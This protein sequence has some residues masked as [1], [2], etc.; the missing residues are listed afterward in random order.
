[1]TWA[2]YIGA[3]WLDE[4]ADRLVVTFFVKKA[5]TFIVSCDIYRGGES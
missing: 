2:A 4:A 3:T 5:M 1:M